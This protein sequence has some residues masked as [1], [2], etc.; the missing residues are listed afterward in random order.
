VQVAVRVGA[1]SLNGVVTSQSPRI[2]RRNRAVRY[3][4]NAYRPL[5]GCKQ[6]LPKTQESAAAD[7]HND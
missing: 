5:L 4:G 6:A 7:S 1:P 3:N 2:S